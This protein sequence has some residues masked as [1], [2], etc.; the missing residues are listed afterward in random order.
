MDSC[1]RYVKITNPTTG[2]TAQTQLLDKCGDVQ[3]STFGKNDIFVSLKSFKKLSGLDYPANKEAGN[4]QTQVK[5]DFVV[6]S[7]QACASG[8][9]ARDEEG[10]EDTCKGR[11]WL[12][13]AVDDSKVTHFNTDAPPPF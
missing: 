6:E 4:L 10:K 13:Q 11:E 3:N 12:A 7:C 2:V 8:V 5:W 9:F 1:Q